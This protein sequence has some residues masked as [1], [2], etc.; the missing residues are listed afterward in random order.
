MERKNWKKGDGILLMCLLVNWS[1]GY[2]RSLQKILEP[3]VSIPGDITGNM[4]VNDIK[5]S[6]SFR[7]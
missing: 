3:T 7:G 5:D 6:L 2:A 1:S 4:I